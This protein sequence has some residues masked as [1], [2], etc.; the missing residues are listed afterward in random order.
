MKKSAKEVLITFYSPTKAAI[1]EEASSLLWVWLVRVL[2]PNNVVSSAIQ[3]TYEQPQWPTNVL[4]ESFFPTQRFS[5][6]NLWFMSLHPYR[7]TLLFW[8]CVAFI[9]L[10]GVFTDLKIIPTHS[11]DNSKVTPLKS[12]LDNECMGTNTTK[13]SQ[14]NVYC[15]FPPSITPKRWVSGPFEYFKPHELPSLFSLGGGILRCLIFWGSIMYLFSLDWNIPS[16]KE[17]VSP[18]SQQALKLVPLTKFQESESLLPR[19]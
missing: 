3:T 7:I 16:W 19:W 12:S 5:P 14:I 17:E 13:G 2:K 8:L 15:L 1:R 6:N 10:G 11:K 18:K 4:G 9:I